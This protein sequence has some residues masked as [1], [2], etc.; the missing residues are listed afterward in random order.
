M[1]RE[2]EVVCGSQA[3]PS[4]PSTLGHF[5]RASPHGGWLYD[6]FGPESSEKPSSPLVS[7]SPEGN[8]ENPAPV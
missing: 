4:A 3:H 6:G 1:G 8:Q 7:N 5:L 2:R